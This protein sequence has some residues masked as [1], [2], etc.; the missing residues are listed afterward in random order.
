MRRRELLAAGGALAAWPAAA[1]PAPV[2]VNLETG[3]GRI[4]LEL[5]PDKA[6]LT[7]ANF[8]RYVD[9]KLY[10]GSTIY[11][12]VRA[13]GLPEPGLI[14]GGL[15]NDPK[16]LLPPVA[17]ESTTQTGILHKDGAISLARREQGSA[18]SDYFICVGDAPYLDANPSQP[19]DNAGFAAFGRVVE[20][21]DVA[22]KILAMP[23][24]PTEG[25]AEMKGQMLE[26]PVPIATARRV[27]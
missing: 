22:R 18:T 16:K 8:L 12:A 13:P 26:P 21:M 4:V 3:A 19:G 23:T 9:R 20:G 24:S 25:S 5:Y 6:P 10:D 15:K 11:R 2:R 14:Q 17:H 1:Q 27:T 7:A